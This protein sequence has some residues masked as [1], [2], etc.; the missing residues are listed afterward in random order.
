MV[1]A[2]ELAEGFADFV[3]GGGFLYAENFVI[4]FLVVVAI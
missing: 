1:F 3:G 2:R 4:I